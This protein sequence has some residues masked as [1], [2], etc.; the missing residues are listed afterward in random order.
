M[1][2][3]LTDLLGTL[4]LF[5]YLGSDDVTICF[6][7]AYVTVIFHLLFALLGLDF[8]FQVYLLFFQSLFILLE[9]HQLSLVFQL[10]VL[11]KLD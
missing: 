1:F 10:L 4:L 2:N 5:E 11:F 8:R 6:D 3:F 7:L 9:S